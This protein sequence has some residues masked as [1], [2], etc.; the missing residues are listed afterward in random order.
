M[1]RTGPQL[2]YKAYKE[3]PKGPDTL[4]FEGIEWAGSLPFLKGFQGRVF[5]LEASAEKITAF[6]I[7][8]LWEAFPAEIVWIR[9]EYD[10]IRLAWQTV[11]APLW[12]S[13]GF[14]SKSLFD[15]VHALASDFADFGVRVVRN[16]VQNHTLAVRDGRVLYGKW[17]NRAAIV[18][19][20]GPSLDL[21]H[22]RKSDAFLIA[23]GSA[24]RRLTEAGIPFHFAVAV[25]PEAK[26]LSADVPLGF[27]SHVCPAM[28]REWKGESWCFPGS[29]LHP[30]EGWLY[31]REEILDGGWNAGTFGFAVAKQFG[32]DPIQIMGIEGIGKEWIQGYSGNR[33]KSCRRTTVLQPKGRTVALQRALSRCQKEVEAIIEGHIH[34][35]ALLERELFY[36][37]ILRPN[38]EIW[39]R[40]LEQKF[41]LSLEQQMA[42]YL[43]VLKEYAYA[44]R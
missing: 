25:D 2:T 42:F 30:I 19:G 37:K 24:M 21:E 14:S 23:C 32:C 10:L 16:M 27:Q 31:R 22:L 28:V 7:D 12:F 35:T 18:C 4:L 38:W 1:P 13:P 41:P 15:Q 20:S 9:S 33:L 40:I 39:R 26:P 8:D 44:L 29:G 3:I 5:L 34:R 11:F 17:Q 6:L 43:T 36:D